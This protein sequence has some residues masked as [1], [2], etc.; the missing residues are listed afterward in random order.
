[1]K[2]KKEKNKKYIET[3]GTPA[4]DIEMA[5]LELESNVIQSDRVQTPGPGVEYLDN[6]VAGSEPW[7]N[8]YQDFFK[9]E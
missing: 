5:S 6:S 7:N 8:A 3:T 2:P 9:R 1:L 4:G